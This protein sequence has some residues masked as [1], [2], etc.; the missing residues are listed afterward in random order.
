MNIPIGLVSLLLIIRFHKE[1]AQ[2]SKTAIDWLCAIT[3][4]TSIVSLMFGLEFGGKQFVWSSWQSISLFTIFTVFF[5][6]FLIAETKAKEPIISFWMFKSR[7]F[8]SSQVLAFLYGATFIGL[9]I[10]IPIFVQAVYGGSASNAGIILM[11]MLLGSV[12]GSA[13]GG[14]L[15]SKA[16]YRKIMAISVIAYSIGMLLMSTITPNTARSSL[17][18][19]MIFVGFGVGFSFSLLPAATVHTMDFRHRGSANST[20]AF[21][22]SLGLALGI[23]IFGAIKT[24]LLVSEMAFGF[25][26]LPGN[27]A[28]ASAF[29]NIQNAFLLE[30]RQAIPPEILTVM[31]NGMSHSISTTFLRAL[32]PVAISI[33]AVFYMGPERLE[34]PSQ[35]TK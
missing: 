28:D 25:A 11:P 24:K 33:V 32:I 16:S 14:V 2:P 21:F 26:K 15:Q 20:N 9:T 31:S 7:L 29:G 34:I 30:T 18:F 4:V 8:A 5:I 22:R 10:F 19:Y 3:L 12:V 23:T 6:F 35:K 17:S 13:L 1:T 27:S